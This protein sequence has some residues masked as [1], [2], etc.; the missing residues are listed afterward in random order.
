MPGNVIIYP[1][2]RKLFLERR[3]PSKDLS[4]VKAVLFDLDNTLMDFMKMKERAIENAVDAMIDAGLTLSRQ[5]AVERINELYGKFGIEYQKIFDEFLKEELGRVDYKILAAGVVA[6]RTIK[7]GYVQ[8]YP[9]VVG[10]VIE[11]IR[12]GFKLALITDAPAFQAWTRLAGMNLHQHFDFVITFEDTGVR[13][14]NELPF[15]A[16]MEKLK[17]KPNELLMVGD[18]P[19]RDIAGAKRFGIPCVLAKYG[20]FYQVDIS[21]KEQIA[22]FEITDISQLLDL[23]PSKAPV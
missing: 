16:A 6:Y 23:L 19:R 5:K 7:E 20:S 17:L 8:P 22:N 10:T 12:R 18:D 21:R 1:Q 13:K 11:L 15:V 14:P 4:R 9:H 2:A 3:M